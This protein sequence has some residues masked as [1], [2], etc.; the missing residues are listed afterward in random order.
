MSSPSPIY[1]SQFIFPHTLFFFLSQIL[2]N[3]K[4]QMKYTNEKRR[5]QK[6]RTDQ[7]L[8]RS[9]SIVSVLSPRNETKH[10]PKNKWSKKKYFMFCIFFQWCSVFEVVEVNET[11]KCWCILFLGVERQRAVH[12]VQKK[13]IYF[14]KTFYLFIWSFSYSYNLFLIFLLLKRKLSW[15]KILSH[16]FYKERGIKHI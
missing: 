14:F 15:Y 8:V 6:R 5:R 4:K 3:I 16:T 2:H 10:I 7:E 12:V 1:S 13:A 11:D 9:L